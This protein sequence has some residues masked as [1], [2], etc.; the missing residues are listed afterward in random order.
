MDELIHP[1]AL[2]AKAIDCDPEVLS[3]DSAMYRD[4]GWDSLGHV[5]VLLSLE[6]YYSIQVDDEAVESSK[7]MR[8]ILELYESLRRSRG[9]CD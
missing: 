4:Y 1:F 3:E 5:Q 2:V 9:S 8:R 6:L 7:T